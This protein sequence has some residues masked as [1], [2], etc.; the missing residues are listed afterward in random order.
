[1]RYRVAAN[2]K[3][4]RNRSNLMKIRKNMMSASIVAPGEGKVATALQL[5]TL[6]I[7]NRKLNENGM[8]WNQAPPPLPS[9]EW[10]FFSEEIWKNDVWEL[11]FLVILAPSRW[12]LWPLHLK[13]SGVTPVQL[14]NDSKWRQRNEI[15]PI[16]VCMK[17]LSSVKFPQMARLRVTY[18][19]MSRGDEC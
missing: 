17:Y 14:A 4:I 2:K 19:C 5:K 16:N 12:E 11:Y 8:K 10:W 9:E 6:C 1:M 3:Q 18:N 7:E 13:I 15:F